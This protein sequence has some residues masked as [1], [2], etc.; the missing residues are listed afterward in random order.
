MQRARF[1]AAPGDA[2]LLEDAVEDHGR[3]VG[4]DGGLPAP[5]EALFEV[6]VADLDLVGAHGLPV[7]GLVLP[8][9]AVEVALEI[10]HR[11]VDLAVV[12]EHPEDDRQELGQLTVVLGF[13]D[14]LALLLDAHHLLHEALVVVEA[15]QQGGHL[16]PVAE[17]VEDAAADEAQEVAEGLFV[18]ADRVVGDAERAADLV[19][20]D[21]VGLG[22]EREGQGRGHARVG[23]GDVGV[24]PGD[25]AADL[26]LRDLQV[27]DGAGL[28]DVELAT[29]E[30]PLDVL[31]AAV[32]GLDGRTEAGQL[33]G[34]RV[35]Q[36]GGVMQLG[37]DGNFAGAMPARGVE[38][39]LH[40]LGDEFGREGPG[41]LGDLEGVGVEGSRDDAFAGAVGAVD[42]EDVAIARQGIGGEHDARDVGG[43]H[44]LDHDR[45]IDG[46]DICALHMP[47]TQRTL[48]IGRSPAGADGC[49]DGVEALHE[50]E[51]VHLAGERVL[52]AVLSEGRRAHGDE[53]VAE[54]RGFAADGVGH[55]FGELAGGDHALD[56]MACRLHGLGA[57]EVQL[58][59]Q[60]ADRIL[61][62]R[63]AHEG[64]EG[65]D[66][67][68]GEAGHG[69]A[70]VGEDPE[71]GGLAT[72]FAF[73]EGLSRGNGLRR[74]GHGGLL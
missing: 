17:V 21:V 45:N 1:V 55:G 52:V 57:G 63:V 23:L 74:G 13:L 9:G 8:V 70:R 71:V 73:G 33:F 4:E 14:V 3:D 39:D 24:V 56:R 6:V 51:G 22:R 5:E 49:E 65:R 2:E 28:Q 36:A 30:G 29:A 10:G 31:G 46:Q 60:G 27:G 25:F 53:G 61:E 11:A 35:A 38:G 18:L 34:L 32:M 58:G 26:G 48:G 69:E 47:V 68:G 20:D 42:D 15:G 19:V 7:G 37:R 72:E 50:E 62:V 40:R 41:V 67:D 12:V 66:R 64:A 44:L 43:D 59:Q 54:G 16:V